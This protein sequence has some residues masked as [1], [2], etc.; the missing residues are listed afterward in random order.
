MRKQILT[1]LVF[2]ALGVASAALAAPGDGVLNSPHNMTTYGY[3]DSNGRV[4]AFCHTPHHA[5]T[6]TNVSDYLP[7]WSRATDTTVFTTA[8]AS[9]T[10][11]AAELQETTSDKAI[12]PTRLCMSCHD[13]TIAP[14]QHYG[15]T[16]TAA[17]LTGDNFPTLG[18]GAGV[19][20]GTAGLSNDH[21]V[22]F[23]YTDVAVGPATGSPSASDISAATA[24]QDPWI[25]Q[26]SVTYTGNTYNI[27]VQDRLYFSNGK[28]YM[29]CATC[30]D[31][32]NK[33]NTY[34]TTGTEPVNYL[35]LAPQKDSA[36][37]LTCHIK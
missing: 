29:T 9:S 7:L 13:G 3:T 34:T 12:G 27:T 36:L 2:G 37:C 14:D 10:I 26:A 23:S 28:S 32:H 18:N 21:P 20:A 1:A 11:N 4:C 16:G 15:N 24:N 25:R 17:M 33:K 31:V 30:H 22:G 19:G 6:S 35:V 8:Y 5:A